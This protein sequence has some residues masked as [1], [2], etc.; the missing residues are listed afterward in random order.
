MPA[1]C[2][3]TTPSTADAS[4]I[5]K[6]TTLTA[7]CT[8]IPPTSAPAQ[9]EFESGAL[10]DYGEAARGSAQGA[11][12]A[13]V[14]YA[15]STA[16]EPLLFRERHGCLL[17]EPSVPDNASLGARRPFRNWAGQHGP[18]H[19]LR[20]GGNRRITLSAAQP[21]VRPPV[22]G[23]PGRPEA[24]RSAQS[25]SAVTRTPT[26]RTLVPGVRSCAYRRP[27]RAV[28]LVGEHL[29]AGRRAP[30]PWRSRRS[31]G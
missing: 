26:R 28:D 30:T 12:P 4:M 29:A 20:P 13:E 23:C 11:R 2:R 31:A 9:E 19:R 24:T 22:V 8:C 10:R 25:A 17:L 6:P 21:G 15:R 16:R 18:P 14:L 3:A 5:T 27:R 7:G 1:C